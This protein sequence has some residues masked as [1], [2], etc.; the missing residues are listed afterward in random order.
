MRA[1]YPDFELYVVD[2]A[3]PCATGALLAL[4]AVRQRSAG[5]TA[6]QLADWANEA[7]DLRARL[8]SL[9]SFDALAAGGRIPPAAAQLT[10]KLDVKPEL[11]STW[12]ARCR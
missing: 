9:E 12:P 3:L 6:K 5:L 2:N 4:E 1:E 7:K 8:L 10:A 11:S